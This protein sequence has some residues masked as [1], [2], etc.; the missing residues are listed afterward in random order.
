MADNNVKLKAISENQT[1]AQ[2]ITTIAEETGISRTDVKTVLAAL[3]NCARRHLMKR[4]SGQFVVPELA[5][6]IRRVEKPAQK[7]RKGRNPATGEEITIKAKPA[8]KALRAV[9]LKGLKDVLA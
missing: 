7:A 5:V 6:K 4:G 8:R 1:K 2:I 9:P 3:A